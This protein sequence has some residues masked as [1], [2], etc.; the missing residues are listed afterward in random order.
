MC[1]FLE[2]IKQEK[3]SKPG[4]VIQG[5]MNRPEWTTTGTAHD[6]IRN[7]GPLNSTPKG[8]SKSHPTIGMLRRSW[9]SV[10]RLRQVAFA[11]LTMREKEKN[12][13]HMQLARPISGFALRIGPSIY[14]HALIYEQKKTTRPVEH[15]TGRV[16]QY[17]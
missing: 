6:P 10:S 17:D 13:R 5:G 3:S 7:R 16:A 14:G 11:A 12:A 9:R 15:R 4:G 1:R 8:S 2:R